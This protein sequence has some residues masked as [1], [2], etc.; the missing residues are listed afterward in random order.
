MPLHK[1]KHNTQLP[2]GWR[3]LI[4]HF[5]HDT[6]AHV[7]Q[8]A[9]DLIM[10]QLSQI[11]AVHWLDIVTDVQLIAPGEQGFDFILKQYSVE[12]PDIRY[13]NSKPFR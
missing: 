13:F 4:L 11:D 7:L 10:T 3:Q 6:L 12:N 9:D 1:Q 2:T 5:Q 8:Q